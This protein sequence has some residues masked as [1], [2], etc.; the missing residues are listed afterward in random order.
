MIAGT[1]RRL[2]GELFELVEL[3]GSAESDAMGWKAL[4]EAATEGRFEALRAHRLTS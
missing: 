3:V 1:T 4:R 2:V